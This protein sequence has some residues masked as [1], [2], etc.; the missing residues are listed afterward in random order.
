MNKWIKKRLTSSVISLG[1]DFARTIAL[2]HLPILFSASKLRIVI[3]LAINAFTPDYNLGVLLDPVKEELGYFGGVHL[4]CEMFRGYQ[5]RHGLVD[6]RRWSLRCM[7]RCTDVQ[8]GCQR[9]V[10]SEKRRSTVRE[11]RQEGGG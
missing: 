9:G 8:S 11:Q 5:E 10:C 2:I 6:L 3:R 4:S 7:G 1:R